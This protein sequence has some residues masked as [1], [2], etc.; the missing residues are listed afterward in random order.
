MRA[1]AVVL[2]EIAW[3]WTFGVAFWA[4]LYYSFREY[5]ASVEISN[6]EYALMRS[7]EPYTWLAITVRVMAAFI[8]GARLLWP[9]L[10]PSLIV[11]W[12]TLAA[13]GR[14]TTIRALVSGAPRTN[15]LSTAALHLLRVV[16][17]VACLLAFLGCGILINNVV[18]DPS[19]HFATTFL[20]SLCSLMVIGFVWS[21]ANW[22]LSLAAI[23]TARDHASFFSSLASTA[24]FYHSNSD[25]LFRSGLAFGLMRTVLIVAATFL[26]LFP[27]ARLSASHAQVAFLV[28]VIVT[29]GYFAVADALNMWRLAS[30]VSLSEPAPERPVLA[31]PRPA[32][33]QPAL[34]GEPPIGDRPNGGSEGSELKADS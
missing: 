4:I 23:F 25:S 26:S 24:D 29:F 16:F 15:W 8:T 14:V 20:L 31:S 32:E 11:L 7:L 12:V 9:V 3:R 13:V 19:Q 6:A 1:P 22:F 2:T 17:T 30:Y 5:F 21:V 28:V 10:V 18:G 33:P 34:L 27:I